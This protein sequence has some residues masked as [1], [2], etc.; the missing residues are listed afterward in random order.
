MT[1]ASSG[2]PQTA[3]PSSAPP[4][5]RRILTKPRTQRH[6]MDEPKN[7]LRNPTFFIIVAT[8]AVAL[9]ATVSFLTIGAI[10]Q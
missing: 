6:L 3:R 9:L 7:P 5:R 1:A 2:S 10:F 4:N 8:I